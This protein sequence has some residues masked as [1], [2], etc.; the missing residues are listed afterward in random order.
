[1]GASGWRLART[2]ARTGRSGVVPG[3]AL[4]T[5]MRGPAG[6]VVEG[7]GAGGRSALPRGPL[8]PDEH[9]DPVYGPRDTPDFARMAALGLPFWIAGGP[10][11]PGQVSRAGVA[12][13]AGVQVGSAFVLCGGRA[14]GRGGAG[15]E[16][17]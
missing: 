12:G 5:L 14:R 15:A 3:T 13:A 2:V 6:F 16:R 1:M 11:G 7:R 4:D 9:G 17:A 10:C 8:R